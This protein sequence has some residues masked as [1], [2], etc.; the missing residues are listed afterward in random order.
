MQSLL[1]RVFGGAAAVLAVRRGE[2]SL[3]AMVALLPFL[4]GVS[5][6]LAELLG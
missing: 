2:R 5:F 4:L 1:R 3:L 6:G